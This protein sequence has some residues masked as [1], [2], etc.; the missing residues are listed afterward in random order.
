MEPPKKYRGIVLYR[1]S[2]WLSKTFGHGRH[3]HLGYYDTPEEAARAYD[4]AQLLLIG[5]GA[6]LNFPGLPDLAMMD[7]V[8]KILVSRKVLRN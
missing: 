8:H 4:C 3:I 2:K 5:P 6:T 7:K 1:N